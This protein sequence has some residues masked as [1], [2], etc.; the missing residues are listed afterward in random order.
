MDLNKKNF[1]GDDGYLTLIGH[2][3]SSICS[4]RSKNSKQH[5]LSGKL[6]GHY[7][8]INISEGRDEVENIIGQHE[9]KRNMVEVAIVMN[10][11]Q[12][13]NKEWQCNSRKLSVCVTSPYVAQVKEIER[14]LW[15]SY[16]NLSKLE[17][18]VKSLEGFQDDEADIVIISTVKSNSVGPLQFILK[19]RKSKVATIKA[20]HCL[21]ILGNGK[22]LAE[23]D[24]VWENILSDAKQCNCY[25]NA[26]EDVEIAQVIIDIKCKLDELEDLLDK[27][28]NLFK[29]TK[30]Q[31]IFSETFFKSFLKLPSTYSKKLVVKFLL[32]LATGWRPKKKNTDVFCD[33]SVKIAKQFKVED[34]YIICTNDIS[35]E[36]GFVTQILKV[37]DILH[38]KDAPALIKRLDKIYGAF[39]KD[40]LICCKEKCLQGN[41]EVPKCYTSFGVARYKRTNSGRN[42]GENVRVK[43]SLLLMKF[44]SLSAGVMSQLLSAPDG[45][46]LNVP[47]EVSDEEREIILN[48]RSSFILGRS[49]TGKTTVLVMKLF[50]KE[51]QHYMASE[52]FDAHDALVSDCL[53]NEPAGR[54]MPLCQIFVTINPKL[55]FAVKQLIN[56]LRRFV[57]G[58]N[59]DKG[60]TSID[61]NVMDE[62]E[63]LMDVPDSF[64]EIPSNAYPLVITFNMFLL[65]LDKTVGVSFFHRFP[66]IRKIQCMKNA[67]FGLV[68]QAVKRKEVDYDKFRTSY[69]PH[70]NTQLTRTLDPLRVFTEIN[71]C[72]KGQ[73]H[74]GKG[75]GSRLSLQSYLKLSKSRVSSFS[76]DE[77]KLIYKIFEDY[78]KKKVVR[79]EFDLSDLVNDLHH[80]L[81]CEKYEGKFMDFVY[82]DEV[83]DLTMKQLALF[84]YIC[85]NVDEGFV[86]AGDTAQTIARGVN[87]RFQDIKCLFYKEFLHG[88]KN[89]GIISPILHLS[90]NFRTHVGVLNLAHSVIELIYHFFPKTIDILNPETSLLCGELPILL[91][92]GIH[93]DAITKIFQD[94]GSFGEGVIRFGAEQVIMVRDDYAREKIANSIGRHAIV[95]TIFESK[96]LEFEDVLLYNFFGSSPLKDQWR[97]IYEFMEKKLCL[98][99]SELYP[100]FTNARHNILCHELKQLYVAITR[101]RQRL[102]IYEASDD[103]SSPMLDYWKRL[104]LVQV[105]KLDDSYARTM[106]AESSL[107][108][109]RRQGIKFVEVH[110]YKAAMQ[111]F[112]RSGDAH[113]KT[114]ARA[115]SLKAAA[116]NLRGLRL[117]ESL[118]MLR[119]AAELFK[120]INNIR[121]SAECYFDAE[122]YRKAGLHSR[123][124]EIY[125]KSGLYN[126][127]L[128]ACNTGK[129]FELGLQ[130]IQSWKQ[131]GLTGSIDFITEEQNFL[132]KGAHAFLQG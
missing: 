131:K 69:W 77:R 63:K 5:Y 81:K 88:R 62:Y 68:S 101:T 21:W 13:L 35:R 111:C 108:D 53:S 34:R 110:N 114:F 73:L 7:S 8:F 126:E 104:N 27:Q 22:T 40:F 45:T 119:E 124:A 118:E 127:C 15:K 120:S 74:F 20:R 47:F 94:K 54:G 123:A 44:Y 26:E 59:F 112:E 89:K 100:S 46:I 103:F 84:K 4:D 105:K 58:E 116:D 37:W 130:Y 24:Y 31:V 51:Q 70:F 43:E 25:F 18:K 42:F 109:W 75:D 6:F 48:P 66:D 23:A 96:G 91:D 61:V 1:N 99:N 92:C 11:L 122:D 83:Q 93:E 117:Q 125:A 85:K 86:F 50:Q 10:I 55:C 107:E 49:G 71:S 28:C 39:S 12:R 17:L 79:G 80:R 14:R 29:V 30:W 52:G 102:W 106:Q 132:R 87:F 56:N 57:H 67:S 16:E 41:L 121:K 76:E 19:H 65:M 3:I 95:L 32:K 97:L 113:W 98:L 129:L 38:L 9:S 36:H 78:E 64:E 115:C 82:I 72:I 2:M 60:C 90:Q 128:H 33:S